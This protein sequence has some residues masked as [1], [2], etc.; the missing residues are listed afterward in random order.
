[1]TDTHTH[2]YLPEFEDG[3]VAAVKA[4]LQ[5]EVDTL[6]FPNVDHTTVL[7]MI[8]LHRLFPDNTSIALGLHPTEVDSS[9]RERIDEIDSLAG[10]A[11]IVAVGEIGMDLY[12]DKKYADLQ[13]Q[14]LDFQ[15][16]RAHE[17]HLPAIIH[18]REALPP[19]LE[20]MQGLGDS[21]P[22]LIFHSFTMGVS[23]VE[24][25]RKVCDPMF[26]INGV[27]TYKNAQSLRDALPEI[28]TGRLLT[29]TDSPYLSPVPHRGRRNESAY[30]PII[31][32]KIAESLS[33]T[34]EEVADAT[35]R[36]AA[37]TFFPSPLNN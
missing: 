30:I 32:A 35:S 17:L 15:L 24:A 12:W 18:C 31:V 2:L 33:L 11:D 20:V 16:R 27:V 3:G 4:A 28:G 14:A 25:I 23:E 36:N 8:R 13:M 1:M 22:P 21:L 5:A 34:A 19:T 26:G 7:P 10:D 37:S 29:E 6:I 9:W